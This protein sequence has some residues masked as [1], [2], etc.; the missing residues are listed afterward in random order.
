MKALTLFGVIFICLAL[1][2]AAFAQEDDVESD[3]YINQEKRFW[4]PVGR[5]IGKQA[6][7]YGFNK[8]KKH[9]GHH[10]G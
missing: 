7:K 6:A 10:K 2:R 4:A 5:W 9:Q 8:W 1:F 3:E